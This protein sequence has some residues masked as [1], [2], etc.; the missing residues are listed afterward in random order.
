MVEAEGYIDW[1]LCGRMSWFRQ[2]ALAFGN[3][4]LGL[5]PSDSGGTESC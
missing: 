5:G 2:E 3:K 4:K 1:Q